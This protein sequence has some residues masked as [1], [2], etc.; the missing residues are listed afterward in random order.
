MTNNLQTIA[1]IGDVHGFGYTRVGGA[2][3]CVRRLARALVAAG[4]RVDYFLFGGSKNRVREVEPGL[5]VRE[6]THLHRALTALKAGQWDHVVEVLVRP[7]Q[8]LAWAGCRRRLQARMTFHTMHFGGYG[9]GIRGDCRRL[10]DR[11]V[12][13]NGKRFVF[14]EGNL[15][16]I[17]VRP[18]KTV[19]LKPPIPDAYY[20][21]LR[22][23]QINRKINVAFVGRLDPEKGINEVI[24]LFER[25]AQDPHM[26]TSIYGYT[27]KDLPESQ[28]IEQ[29]LRTH[30][31]IRYISRAHN[32]GDVPSDTDLHAILRQTDIMILPY[33]AFRRTLDPPLLLLEAMASLCLPVTRPVGS[34]ARFVQDQDCLITDS[35]FVDSAVRYID[36]MKQTIQSRREKLHAWNLQHA[37][38][39][40]RSAKVFLRHLTGGE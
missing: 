37:C 39:T 4:H 28:R 19:L 31:T 36:R 26:R 10:L 33:Q 18:G 5:T 27:W 22:E 1:F 8:Q 12:P 40:S 25:W 16:M 17:P 9:H 14:N 3:S 2:E 15:G 32:N 30:K 23:K 35:G 7:A 6:F 24:A 20:L 21:H 11:V 34:V 13:L 29:Y 38:H